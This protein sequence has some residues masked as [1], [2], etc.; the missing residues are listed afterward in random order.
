MGARS[1]KAFLIFSAPAL[2]E[3]DPVHLGKVD[4]GE[5]WWEEYKGSILEKVKNLTSWFAILIIKSVHSY[6]R[7]SG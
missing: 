3:M 7:S 2:G 1:N 6:V 5:K 4:S